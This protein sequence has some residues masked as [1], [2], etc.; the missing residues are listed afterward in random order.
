F[1]GVA[2]GVVLLGNG[3]CGDGFAEFWHFYIG[4]ITGCCRSRIIRIGRGGLFSGL[5]LFFLLRL[6]L[7]LVLLVVGRWIGVFVADACDDGA[8]IDGV[9]FVREDFDQGA[10]YWG[11]DLGID[12]V[13][14]DLE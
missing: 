12:L 2:V 3:A 8:D 4:G 5:G 1:V 13:G 7:R 10:C 9:V 11:R 14:G 6:F